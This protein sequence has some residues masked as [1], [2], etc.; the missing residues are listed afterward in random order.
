MGL[1]QDYEFVHI[2]SVVMVDVQLK[3]NMKDKERDTN[4]RK[5]YCTISSKFFEC[6]ILYIDKFLLKTLKH[7]GRG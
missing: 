5:K 2:N 6:I 1:E 3:Q 4:T 7:V